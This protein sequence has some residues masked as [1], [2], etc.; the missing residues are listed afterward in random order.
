MK[1]IVQRTAAVVVGGLA[2]LAAGGALALLRL[3]IASRLSPEPF[4]RSPARLARGRYLVNHVTPCLHCHSTGLDDRFAVP[5]K[6]GTEGQGGFVFGPEHGVPGR[7]AASNITPDRKTGLG[8]WSDAEVLR[9]IRVGVDASGRAL[10]PMMPY[11]AFRELSDEDGAAIVVYLRTLPAIE[12]EVPARRLDFPVNLLVR[13]LPKPAQGPPRTPA[14]E[15]DH[16]AYGG[17]LATVAGCK[18]CHTP[19]DAHGNKIAGA[20][21]SGGWELLGPWGRVVSSNLTPHADTFV[22]RATKEEFIGRFKAFAEMTP[23]AA[24]K[25]APGRNTVMPWLGYAGMTE[26]DLGAIYDFLRS[27]PARARAVVSFPDA[28]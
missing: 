7:L 16:L 5:P 25:V 15:A 6:P 14:D 11:P 13:T 17:Y 21:F 9:A 1:K 18:T 23:E 8:E 19:Q 10:F 3:P 4:E 28:R 12:H 20:D 2:I 24:P 26:R 22:G 27:R